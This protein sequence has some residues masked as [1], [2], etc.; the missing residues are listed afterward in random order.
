MCT[1]YIFDTV[2]SI[3]GKAGQ[4]IQ[5]FERDSGAKI[6]VSLRLYLQM[7]ASMF[8]YELCMLILFIARDLHTGF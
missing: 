5:Q 7:H 1:C 3:A 4:T 2:Q 8:Y 6:K